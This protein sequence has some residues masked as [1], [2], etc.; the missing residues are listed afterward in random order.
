MRTSAFL[1]AF[2]ALALSACKAA[3]GAAATCAGRSPAQLK[4]AL[5]GPVRA[6]KANAPK[7]DVAKCTSTCT[8]KR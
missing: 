2:A 6:L 5:V 4:S 1:F 7:S 8:A 3:D